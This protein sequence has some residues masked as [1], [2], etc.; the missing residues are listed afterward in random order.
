MEEWGDVGKGKMEEQKGGK[1]KNERVVQDLGC[2]W[3]RECQRRAYCP[4]RTTPE[5]LLPNGAGVKAK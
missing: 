4:Y 3:K 1:R 5:S 2:I